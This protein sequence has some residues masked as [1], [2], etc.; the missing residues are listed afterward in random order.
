[1]WKVERALGRGGY[2][3]VRLE[4]CVDDNEKRAV[5]RIWTNG[6]ALKKEYERELKALLEF[7]KPKYKEAAAFVEFLGWFEDLESVYLAMEYA[8]LGDLEDNVP[9]KP[10]AIREPEIR[11]ITFQILERLKIIHKEAFVHRDLK[12]KVR[13]RVHQACLT[14]LI[15]YRM[16]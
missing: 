3:E 14:L 7:S 12:P 2:G 10:G 1:V 6:S 15:E 8:A 4:I 16:S 11:D 9:A 13:L 5:K